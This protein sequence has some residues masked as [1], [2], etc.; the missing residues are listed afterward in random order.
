M[1]SQI[2]VSPLRPF[3]FEATLTAAVPPDETTRAKLRELY[4]AEG[5]LVIRGQSLSMAEQI[6]FCETFGPTVDHPYENFYVSNTRAD[7]V[8]GTRELLFHNDVPFLPV[9]YQGVSM[10]AVEVSG[11][12]APTRF[13]S[14]FRAHERLPADLRDR[15]AALNGLQVRERVRSR[16]TGLADL[17]PGDMCT[18]HP[19]VRRQTG[20][21]RPY[22]FVNE[23][24]TACLLGLAEAD[25]ESLLET[26]FGHFYAEDEVYEHH[27]TVGDLVI[28]DNL[29]VQHA[30]KHALGA[31][32]TLQRVTL[33]QFG[34]AE[35]YPGD[36]MGSDLHNKTLL[37]PAE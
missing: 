5:L 16:R 6:A 7:G 30:R 33:A 10:L 1:T 8:L 35:Q 11:D 31:E 23:D 4:D 32:R 9:P 12:A 22:L 18:V 15:V 17:E 26:L 14:G 27:W 19:V 36:C 29:A 2:T 28:W 24:M 21:G 20:T 3:G 34:Y 37:V 25:S 13:V